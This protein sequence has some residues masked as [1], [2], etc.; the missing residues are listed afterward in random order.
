KISMEVMANLRNEVNT[1]LEKDNG[2]PYLNIAYEEVLFPVVFTGK[3]K[4]Y[5]LENK[6]K[7]NF[8]PGKEIINRTLKI[9][10]EETVH[11]IV[12]KVLW[13]NVENLS[14]L[15]YDEFIQT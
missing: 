10:N 5:G 14:K 12:E 7:P 4:Y 6:N 2:T 8:N 15:D 1:E 11:Q 13:K 3:K 9:G